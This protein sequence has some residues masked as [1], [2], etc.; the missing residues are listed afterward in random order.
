MKILIMGAQFANKGAQSMLFS[1]MD[2]FRK[3]YGDVDVYFVPL[4]DHQQYAGH[5]YKFRVIYGGGQ[6]QAYENSSPLRRLYLCAKVT[7]RSLVRKGALPL[8]DVRGL[9]DALTKVDVIVDVSGYSIT[10]KWKIASNRRYLWRVA[11]AKKYGKK[12]IVL[13]Q[14]FGPFDFGEHQAEMDARIPAV[15]SQVDL[16]FARETEG[17]RLLEEKYGLTNVRLSPDSV[18]QA[19]K[20]DWRNIMHHAPELRYPRLATQHNVGIIPNNQA[21][22][23]GDAQQILSVYAR[24][25][26]ELLNRGKHIYIFRHSNDQERCRQIHS[27][28]ASDPNVTLIEQEFSCW[29]YG[30]FIRQFEFVIASRFHA[31]VHAYKEGVPVLLL[32]WAAKYQELADLFGQQDYVFDITNNL[33]DDSLL[34]ALD[35]LD[36]SSEAERERI[37]RTLDSF[38][39]NTCFDACWALLDGKANG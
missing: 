10:S 22:Q 1:V 37:Q 15:M 39:G 25:I 32:G 28:F 18:L 38:H 30:E 33:Q 12:I 26:R 8:R 4:D 16:L 9:H 11:L 34:A 24:V 35:K 5:R 20:T 31:I 17:K 13:P 36:A 14:S 7:V 3:H 6:A 19:G 2:Q 29:E 23:S 21:F 27:M